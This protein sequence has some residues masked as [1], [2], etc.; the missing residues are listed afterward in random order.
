MRRLAV[1]VCLAGCGEER[2]GEDASL[3]PDSAEMCGASAVVFAGE[4]LDWDSSA[5]IAGA[6]LTVQGGGA[7]ATTTANGRWQL[8]LAN[9][10]VVLVD[11]AAPAGYLGGTI[12]VFKDVLGANGAFS[13]RSFTAA[14]GQQAPFLYDATRAQVFVH[15]IGGA[16]PVDVSSPHDAGFHFTGSAWAAGQTGTDVYVPN[17]D[18]AGGVAK[19]AVDSGTEIGTV[20]I[21]AGAFTYVVAAAL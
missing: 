7:S 8:C 5:A 1:L 3:P 20:P 9:D 21:T 17:I 12:A 11:V 16:R 6:T 13:L 2:A 14:R 4:L 19:V 18:P 10:T 15:V